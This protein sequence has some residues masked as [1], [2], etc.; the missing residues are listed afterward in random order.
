MASGKSHSTLVRCLKGV[1][2]KST[3]SCDGE[4]HFAL[5]IDLDSLDERFDYSISARVET[6]EGKLWGINDVR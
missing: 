3:F 5:K 6:A 4:Q 1:E 2:T